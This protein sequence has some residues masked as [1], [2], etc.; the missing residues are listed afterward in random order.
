M[1]NI[2]LGKYLPLD[3][4][5]HR[6]DPRAKIVAM[7]LLMI[8]IFF[9][10]GWIGHLGMMSFLIMVTLLA[11]LQLSFVW[12][13]MKPMLFML[14]FL[15]V[16]NILLTKD[17]FIVFSIFGFDIYSGAFVQ[18]LMITLRLAYMVMISTVLTATTKPLELTLGIEDL[19]SPLKVIK[20]PAHQFA[21]MISIALRFIPTLI[22]ETQRIMKAQAS[23]GVDLEEG[24]L[25]DKIKAMISLIIPLFVSA[26]QRALDLADAMEA[27]G[28][29]PD[30]K[31]TRYHQLKMTGADY[32][33]I[34]I[35]IGVLACAIVLAYL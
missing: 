11:K 31:R 23:R 24:K 13:A 26:I 18:T 28:Y 21:M 9:N 25:M 16:I 3:S 5:V 20:V 35:C 12:R 27:R 33:M 29:I 30:Q 32:L 1:D 7:I 15:L 2:A 19:L 17:G 22:E 10:I 4:I 34:I 14:S 6:F 8:S